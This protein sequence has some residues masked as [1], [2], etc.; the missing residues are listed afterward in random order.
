MM[1]AP[2]NE[3][4]VPSS[5]D[6]V[7]RSGF[8]HPHQASVALVFT[9]SAALALGGCQA[10]QQTVRGWFG[11]ESPTAETK[12]AGAA[13]AGVFY[14][15]TADLPV[16]SK[17]AASSAVIGKL[18]L[19]E[20]VTRSKLERGYAYVESAPSGTKGWVENARLLWRVP[21]APP[22]AAADSV[23]PAPAAAPAPVAAPPDVPEVDVV[24]ASAP[25]APEPTPPASGTPGIAP[26]IFNPY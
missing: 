16:Y 4:R 2:T 12:A 9:V 13:V 20:K 14:A 15:G 26:S 21:S 25:A 11:G 8:R 17:P 3:Q 5:R 7:D 6:V 24:P 18:G 1:R 23:P 10:T 22:A 19:H